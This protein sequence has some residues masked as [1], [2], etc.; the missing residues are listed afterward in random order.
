[1]HT[2]TRQEEQVEQGHSWEA[3]SCSADQK[4]VTVHNKNLAVPYPEP[5]DALSVC[6]LVGK[7]T[8]KLA[9]LGQF[10]SLLSVSFHRPSTVQFHSPTTDHLTFSLHRTT[11]HP[12]HFRLHILPTA[13]NVINLLM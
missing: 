11:R 10:C 1:M 5:T 13:N 3:D 4:F 9:F 6:I 8:I 12:F 2:T 7:I